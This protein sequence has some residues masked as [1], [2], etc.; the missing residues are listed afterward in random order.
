MIELSR[1]LIE[2]ALAKD[3]HAVRVLIDELSPVIQRRVARVLLRRACAQSRDVREEVK[4]LTQHVFVVL[5][6]EEGRVMRQWDPERGLSLRNFVGLI[7]EREVGT[8]LRSRRKSPWTEEAVALEDLEESADLAGGPEHLIASKE[9]AT[10]ILETVR[11][12]LTDHGLELFHLLIVEERSI[13]EVCAVTGKSA[14]AIY[15][16]R[17][18]L[19]RLVMKVAQEVLSQAAPR[20]PTLEERT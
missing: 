5:F 12:Q 19:G 9:M 8:V 13:E 11:K 1:A 4:D 2:K 14:D 18:R 20:P 10:C 6:A 16:W 7:A 15:A 3:R 17:S